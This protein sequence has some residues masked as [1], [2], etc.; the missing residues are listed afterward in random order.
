MTQMTPLQFEHQRL[1]DVY[2]ACLE[3]PLPVHHRQG[4]R[5]GKKT[6]QGI[7]AGIEDFAR[8][9]NHWDQLVSVAKNQPDKL[10]LW[11]DLHLGHTNVIGYSGRPF[12]SVEQ[13]NETLLAHAQTVPSNDWLLCLGD[14]SMGV[15]EDAIHWVEQVPTQKALVWGNHD[16][17]R[18]Q[19]PSAWRKHFKAQADCLVIPSPSPSYKSLW[20]T[21]YP[22]DEANIPEKVLNIHGHIHQHTLSSR[23]LNVSVEQTNYKPVTLASLLGV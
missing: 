17:D 19:K 23:H 15:L 18:Q 4:A 6:R 21:H 8:T 10:W 14:L 22:L 9:K 20:L 2:H 12:V 5:A 13:M 7:K 1:R 3:L 11:S 16:V